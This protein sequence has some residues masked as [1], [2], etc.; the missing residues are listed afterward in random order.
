MVKLQLQNEIGNHLGK[1]SETKRD[2]CPV[3]SHFVFIKKLHSSFIS[4]VFTL[5]HYLH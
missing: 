5:A 2:N 3:L 4:S 1:Q